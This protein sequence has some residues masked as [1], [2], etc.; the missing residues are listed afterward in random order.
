VTDSPGPGTS[1][2]R[3]EGAAERE[4]TPAAVQAL[5]AG[6]Y[7]AARVWSVEA[8]DETQGSAS[9]LRLQLAYED[10]HDAGLPERMFLK[11]N[12][13]KF[14]FPDEMYATEVFFYRDLLPELDIEAPAVYGL[15]FDQE[16]LRFRILMEDLSV[17]PGAH[18]GIA[19]TP[20]TPESVASVLATLAR[21]HARY[22]RSERLERDLNWLQTPRASATVQFWQKIGP[23]LVARHVRSGH[24]AD[25]V[26]GT[27][28]REEERLW[29]AFDRLADVNGSGPRTVLHGDVHAGNVYYNDGGPGGLI[30]W[31]L[32][33]QGSWAL[34]V[35]Y[36]IVTALDPAERARSERELLS[37][38]LDQLRTLGVDP[39]SF[40]DAWARYRQNVIWSVMMWL[41]TPDGVHTDEVQDTN[42]ANSCLAGDQLDTLAQLGV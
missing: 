42:L 17:R 16:H 11:R 2:V 36:L 30:D 5:L 27:P 24:R 38:Y 14:G 3:E 7:P 12:L 32:M 20:E 21:L 35:G 37:G 39:P 10:G 19:T 40:D 25:I 8:L 9:R 23:R 15:A 26:A 28:W 13:A 22:W 31:Q 29:L 41:I 6:R 18:L 4:L 34:D 33:L 1:R